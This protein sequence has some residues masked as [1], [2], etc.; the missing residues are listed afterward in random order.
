MGKIICCLPDIAV[1]ATIACV[2]Q[3]SVKQVAW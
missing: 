1:Y 3:G 2:Y